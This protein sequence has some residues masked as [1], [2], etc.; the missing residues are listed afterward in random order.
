MLK[1]SANNPHFVLA[2]AEKVKWKNPFTQNYTNTLF[3]A[4]TPHHDND[5]ILFAVSPPG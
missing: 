3:F 1:Q 4:G 5:V 2:Y